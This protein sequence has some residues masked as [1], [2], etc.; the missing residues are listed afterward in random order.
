MNVAECQIYYADWSAHHL[1]DVPAHIPQAKK[2]KRALE[3]MLMRD[4]IYSEFGIRVEYAT[5][6]NDFFRF[7]Q[8]Y[9]QIPWIS[10][11]KLVVR[12]SATA[13]RCP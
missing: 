7:E 8:H 6:L 13:K 12:E 11:R 4:V 3:C 2:Q 9:P 5:A 10:L 1:N